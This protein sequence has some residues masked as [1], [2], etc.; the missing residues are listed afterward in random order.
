MGE[1]EAGSAAEGVEGGSAGRLKATL[2]APTGEPDSST[3]AGWAWDRWWAA[4]WVR[5]AGKG[6]WCA[7]GAGG[8]GG[9]A[10][11]AGWQ[12]RA[13]WEELPTV[14][15][16][17]EFDCEWEA[18]LWEVRASLPVCERSWA[19]HRHARSQGCRRPALRNSF[20]TYR[21]QTH[22]MYPPDTASHACAL[23]EGRPTH[24][25]S[26]KAGHAGTT[27]RPART[28]LGHAPEGTDAPFENRGLGA[29]PMPSQRVVRAPRW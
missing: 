23:L 27:R 14:C 28:A 22:T 7:R 11:G 8:K 17:C 13:S 21:G 25:A 16:E 9:V 6:R 24:A 10:G 15:E 20:F 12:A 4:R 3:M 1:G 2:S 19:A 18:A 26:L 29:Q 5:L